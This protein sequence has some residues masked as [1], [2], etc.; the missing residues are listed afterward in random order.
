M[1][2]AVIIKHPGR[3][4]DWRVDIVDVPDNTPHEQI[5]TIINREMLG[6]FEIISIT[7]KLNLDRKIDLSKLSE[8]DKHHTT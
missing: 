8:T 3:D 4:F 1:K 7:E 2:L 5:K 6:P